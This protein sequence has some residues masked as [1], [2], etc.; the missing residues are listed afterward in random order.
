M[1]FSFA[2]EK[3]V[4]GVV[5]DELGPAVGAT[6]A[7]KGTKNVVA[8]D[9]DGK[10]SIKAKSGDVLEVSYLG[11]KQTVTVGAANS[12]NVTLKSVELKEVV[13]SVGVF[14]K[15]ANKVTSAI[16]TVVGEEFVKQAPSLSFQN[17][18]QGKAAGVQVTAA[19]GQPGQRGYVTIRGNVSITGGYSG[20]TYVVDGAFVSETEATA[21]A[22]QDI[23][24]L[25][26]LKD[27]AAAAIYGSRGGNGVVVITTRKGKSGKT[28]FELNSSF[29]YTQ[30][31]KDPFTLMNAAQ[32][33]D[34]EQALGDG[35]SVTGGFTPAQLDVLRSFDVDWE[36]E[37]L[38]KGTSQNISFS[39]STGTDNSKHFFSLGYNKD[40]GI[41]KNLDGYDRITSAYSTDYKLNNYL[42]FGI[43]FRGSYEKNTLPRDRYNSQNPF[44][45]MYW[46]NG[47]EPVYDRDVDTGELILDSEGQPV[48]NLTHTGFPIAEA[49]LNNTEDTR[50][51]RGYVRPYMD[52]KIMKDLTFT[53]RFAANYER[54][55]R[56]SFV[57]PGS[58]L[59]GYVG[60]PSAPGSKTDNGWDNLDLQWTNILKY[61]FSIKEKHN[62]EAIAMYD[63]QKINFRS[64]S[65]TRKGFLADL[66]TAGTTP[67]AASVS[68]TEEVQYGIFGNIDY[69]YD[70]KYLLAIYGRKDNSSLLGPKTNGAF[71]K[72]A[73]IG[74]VV[75]KDFLKDSNTLNHLKLRASWGELNS[76]NGASRYG[77]VSTFNSTNYANVPGTVLNGNRIANPELKFEQAV[78]L[79][80][81]FESRW[82]NDYLAVSGSY[83]KDERNDFL[84]GDVTP[85]G[86]AWTTTRNVGDW[87]AKGF[88]IEMK[89][90]AIK[91]E[92]MNLSFYVNAAQFDR[93]INSLNP[94]F[95]DEILRGYTKNKVG[96]APDTF[97]L[98]RY[99]G[100][101]PTNGDALYYDIDGNIT[102][103]YSTADRVELKDKT[104]YAKYEG[105]FGAEFTYKGFDIAADFVFKQG[106]YSY[107][108]KYRDLLTD[109]SVISDNQI[110]DAFDYW[111]PTNTDASLP[112][113]FQVSGVDTNQDSD[114][115]LQD[116]SYVR[117]R[118]LN[119]G[120]TFSK[121]LFKNVPLESVRVYAQIQNLHTWT[122]FEGDPEVGIGN[123]E[124]GT[125]LPGQYSG[126]SYPTTKSVLFGINVKF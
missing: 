98:V 38:R 87:V 95:T 93:K 43:N 44:A 7:V 76:T 19:N 96:L 59:D 63:Y 45:A 91:K 48:Y 21:I 33:I 122:K 100:V 105:G 30:R 37:L 66:P 80:L 35:G 12:Y 81:G 50:F 118:N 112:A 4:T 36:D 58:V 51:F 103:V 22:P 82:F 114:R 18:L 40:T 126:Y 49:L 79:D 119:F 68:R 11:M 2:Q 120:Y 20:A 85:D 16:S 124:S 123:A 46:Y 3:T 83:F 60:D 65:Q 99:A 72:G 113:P 1:Q 26:V 57:K 31:L 69:D 64:H 73:S 86:G 115:W 94:P 90:F 62:F 10:Y 34:Y 70:G 14:N 61:N 52:V 116:A 17:A 32:K 97:F 6:V 92:D 88:E 27:G 24:S 39:M 84:F 9:F 101:D 42:N 41:I 107:N 111:T 5:S 13:V 25:T 125:V 74:W 121:N 77:V 89:A 8:T 56:E 67:T 47:Y 55:Q 104:P 78:K 54:Y 102:N 53:T 109:G 110:V 23:E 108:L 117:F 29:G 71:A 106:N 28:S 15:A 75:T